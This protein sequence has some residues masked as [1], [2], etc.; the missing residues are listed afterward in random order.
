MTEPNMPLPL[1]S[2]NPGGARPNAHPA[3][4]RT[5]GLGALVAYGVGDMIGSGVYGTMGKAAG[6]MGNAVWLAFLVSMVAALLTGLSYAN[7]ASRYPR[8]GGAAYVTQRAYRV[9]FLAYVVGLTTTAS[10]LTSMATQGNVFAETIVGK[11]AGLAGAVLILVFLLALAA[12]N[13]WGIRESMWL[14]LVCTTVEVGGLVFIIAVGARFWGGVDYLEVPPVA[15]ATGNL[16]PGRLS[17]GLLMSG[18]VLAFFAFIGFEDLLNVSEEVKDPQRTVPRGLVLSLLVATVLYIAVA[19]TAVSV[20][21]Y[22]ELANGDKGA[23]FAQITNRASPWLSPKVFTGITLFAVTNTA[24]ANYIMGSRLL[25][26]MARQGLVPRPLAAVNRSRRTPHVAIL[27]MLAVV[28]VLA[29]AGGGV[30]QLAT[31]T[32]LLL[33]AVFTVVNVALIVLKRR[34]GEARGAFEVPSVVP[35]LGTLMC[36]S[37]IGYRVLFPQTPEDRRAPWVAGAILA[38]VAVLYL[39]MRPKNVVADEEEVVV[40]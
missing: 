10:G 37:L 28:A 38:A 12:V 25:Y 5:M 35:A 39:V 15:D 30:K 26:G 21:P 1:N 14:N 23:P 22:A 7:I 29:F 34:P 4:A 19:I 13:L 8:A 2:A 31:A 9:A 11:D 24:M 32:S 36:L 16:V 27:A 33:L 6:T 18:A 20:V 40:E 17:G 3:L